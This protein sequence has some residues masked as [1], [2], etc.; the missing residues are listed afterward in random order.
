[1]K[2][3]ISKKIIN[4]F[5]AYFKTIAL[6]TFLKCIPRYNNRIVE[7]IKTKSKVILC[8]L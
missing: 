3:E 2:Y 6:S 5:L 4:I 7:I 8:L 1:M